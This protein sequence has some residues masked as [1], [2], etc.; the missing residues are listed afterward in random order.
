LVN[1]SSKG[2]PNWTYCI[3]CPHPESTYSRKP[4][5]LQKEEGSG[6]AAT[7]KL[8]PQQKLDGCS[9]TRPLLSLCDQSDP[10]SS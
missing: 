5:P 8:L 10:H 2:V 6:H 9:V 3:E 1:N 4:H 7:I